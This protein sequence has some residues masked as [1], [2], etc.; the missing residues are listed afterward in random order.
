MVTLQKIGE[1]IALIKIF[2]NAFEKGG[3]TF[4][5]GMNYETEENFELTGGEQKFGIKEIEVYEV[6]VE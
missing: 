5:K 2:D 1:E 4:E 6:I 3:T